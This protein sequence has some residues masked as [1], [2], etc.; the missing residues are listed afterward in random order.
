MAWTARKLLDEVRAVLQ[1]VDATRYTDQ[2]I[3]YGLQMAVAEM[4]RIRPDYFVDLGLRNGTPE[5]PEVNADGVVSDPDYKIPLPARTRMLVTTFV[6]GYTELMDTQFTDDKR[7]IGLMALMG[8][9]LGRPPGA[10]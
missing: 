4:F 2:T 8:S 7:A 3:L 5:V 6:A 1:D 10:T 9:S